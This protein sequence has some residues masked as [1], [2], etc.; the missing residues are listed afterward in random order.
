MTGILAFRVLC[1][2]IVSL[3]FSEKWFRIIVDN[4]KYTWRDLGA[5]FTNMA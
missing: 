2:S 3:L 5:P 1:E 4:L